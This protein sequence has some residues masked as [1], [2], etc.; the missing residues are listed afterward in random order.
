MIIIGAK[1]HAKEIFDIVSIENPTS[2]YFF[3]NVNTD[4]N[5][6]LFSYPILK[7]LAEAEII[8]QEDPSFILALGGVLN[9]QK[10]YKMFQKIKGNPVSVIASNAVVSKSAVLGNALNIMPFTF[11]SSDTFIGNGC[12]I[13]S[14]AS[15]HHDCII[16]EFVEISPGARILGNC[17]IGALTTIGANATILPKL[18]IGKNV[19][20][21]AGAVVTKNVEDNAIIV[22]IPGK[23]IKYNKPL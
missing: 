14:Y 3:D 7:S 12:L 22:G 15:I 10:V 23:V 16:H 18:K 13:N 9:R 8:L 4:L 1:G 6:T 20:I 19:T 17:Q 2:F 21:G 11:I 5:N